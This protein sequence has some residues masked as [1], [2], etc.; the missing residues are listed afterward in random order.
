MALGEL[1]DALLLASTRAVP[2]KLLG[3]GFRF[4]DSDIGLALARNLG[5]V[6]TLSK[7][8]WIARPP[9]EVFPFFANANN[10]ERI[11]PPWLRFKILNPE[12]EMRV[13]ARIVYRLHLHGIPLRW[14]SEIIDWDPPFRFV[15]VQR[16]GPYS[17]WV[18]EHRFE[19]HNG[20]TLVRDEVEYAAPGGT[21]IRELLIDRDLESIFKYRRSRLEEHFA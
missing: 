1:A 18:H 19:R 15:D 16:R 11:T 21:L 10:L 9:E 14:E 8:Q 13:G 17:L 12:V 5:T 6:S 2:S 7:T 3:S 4:H 20:G